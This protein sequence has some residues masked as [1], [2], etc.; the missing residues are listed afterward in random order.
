MTK[1][2]D[3]TKTHIFP[4]PQP[5]D[6]W[7]VLGDG[8]L[9]RMLALA[10]YPLGFRSLVL[11]EASHAPAAQVSPQFVR[12]RGKSKE[13]IHALLSQV[14]FALIE[15]EFVDCALIESTGLAHKVI[16][17]IQSIGVLQ[18]KF[19]Q[20]LLLREL[21]IPTADFIEPVSVSKAD[22]LKSLEGIAAPQVLKFSTL[23][24]DGKGVCVLSGVDTK[25]DHSKAKAFLERADYLGVSVYSEDRVYFTHEVAMVSVRSTKGA[26]AHYPLVVT[27]QQNGICYKVEGPSKLFGGSDKHEELAKQY[28]EKL[29][30]HL[31]I[32]G[33]FAIEYFSDKS[34]SLIVNEIAPR[35]HNSGHF[36]M[37]ASI[38]SQFANHWL[39]ISG[40]ELGDTTSQGVYGMINILGPVEY[41]T[42]E[43]TPPPRVPSNSN[44]HWYAKRGCAPG[45][46]L[47]HINVVAGSKEELHTSMALVL[48][49]IAEWEAHV[50]SLIP[51]SP[52]KIN[53]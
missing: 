53:L 52:P 15:S 10:G 29:A 50:K 27:E 19:S 14:D 21:S 49:S 46:K 3:I 31:G 24:Y 23:G 43:F 22:F 37:D 25:S 40:L 45:R 11:S 26:F 48:R 38:T 30:N 1:S 44:L 2:Q 7:G 34:G 47:G 20:K 17:S 39:A 51:N 41:W 28:A 6:L 32:V 13:D 4:R 42:T 18:N 12:G 5:K 36:T 9:A 35:V 8:Q 33:V 16:P